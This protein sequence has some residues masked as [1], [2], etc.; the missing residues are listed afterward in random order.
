MV[1]ARTTTTIRVNVARIT[2]K[3]F[4]PRKS[5]RPPAR[6]SHLLG[7][8][9]AKWTM[10]CEPEGGREGERKSLPQIKES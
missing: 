7:Y 3:A 9:L 8:F 5:V 10:E 4:T 6:L 1:V 2:Q